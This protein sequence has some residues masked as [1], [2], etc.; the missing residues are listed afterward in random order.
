MEQE[1]LE[2]HKNFQS[3]LTKQCLSTIFL[4]ST[5][6]SIGLYINSYPLLLLLLA[7]AASLSLVLIK[8]F[9]IDFKEAQELKMTWK[10]NETLYIT[11]TEAAI[12]LVIG[13]TFS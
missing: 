12:G 11:A 1:Q 7:I 3:N 2:K 8:I 6:S 4:F 5:L 10:E 13:I 9:K